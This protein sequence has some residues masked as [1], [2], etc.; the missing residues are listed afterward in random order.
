V[1]VAR[2]FFIFSTLREWGALRRPGGL[3]G[4]APPQPWAPADAHAFQAWVRGRTGARPCAEPDVLDG[5]DVACYEWHVPGLCPPL[6]P[7]STP[8]Q[9]TAGTPCFAC[10]HATAGVLQCLRLPLS[11]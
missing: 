2:D 3:H 7:H 1:P 6:A 8:G 5:R 10:N 4:E 9:G 11:S